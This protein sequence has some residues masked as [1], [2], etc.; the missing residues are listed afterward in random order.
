M[1]SGSAGG[2]DIMMLSACRDLDEH[3]ALLTTTSQHSVDFLEVLS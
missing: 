2:N 1:Q 3:A